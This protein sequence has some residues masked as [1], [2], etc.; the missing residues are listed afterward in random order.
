MD[1]EIL[2]L[3]DDHNHWMGVVDLSDQHISYYNPNLSC[4]RNWIPMFIQMISIIRSNAYKAHKNHFKSD[5]LS[6]KMFTLEMISCLTKRALDDKDHT[7]SSASPSP[8]SSLKSTTYSTKLATVMQ[9]IMQKKE[10][11]MKERHK[12]M[13]MSVKSLSIMLFQTEMHSL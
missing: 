12:S 3:I 13:R 9:K 2:R 4:R 11:E 5:A 10:D 6:H 8:V 1:I 7:A